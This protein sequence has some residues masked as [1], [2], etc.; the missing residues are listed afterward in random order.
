MSLDELVRQLQQVHGDALRAVVLYGSAASGEQVVGHSDFNVLVIVSSIELAQTRQLGQTMRAWQEAGNPPVLVLTEPEWLRSADIFPME[1]ADILERH[2]VLHG[3]LSLTDLVVALHDLRWQTEQEAMGKL[4]RLRRGV[5]VAGTDT[6]RQTDLLRS[7]YSALLV[8]FRAVLRLHGVTPARDAT[9]V[10]Q[11]V[12]ARCGFDA[13]PFMAVSALV[14]GTALAPG[15][16][17]SVLAGY[18]SG[19][20][21]LV[22]YLDQFTPP[23]AAP[24]VISPVQS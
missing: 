5:M 19:M 16:T 24:A 20:D 7:S 13:A 8:I 6:A 23:P 2:R 12:A 10:I 15:A 18:L 21:T 14:R 17:E 3:T 9:R 4:L 22:A 1:Y 11:D